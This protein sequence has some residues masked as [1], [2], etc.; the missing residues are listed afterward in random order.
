MT[1]APA[2]VPPI[3]VHDGREWPLP[4]GEHVIGRG[5]DAA[6]S[7]AALVEETTNVDASEAW[8]APSPRA[9]ADIVAASV[10]PRLERHVRSKSRARSSRPY[11]VVDERP[12]CCAASS[13]VRHSR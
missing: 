2:P 4:D 9:V 13:R 11:S 8:A 12:S 5:D 7:I 1:A 10:R 6:I 3:V